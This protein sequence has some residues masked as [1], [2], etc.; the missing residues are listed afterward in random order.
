MD[1][2]CTQVCLRVCDCICV[3]DCVCV[4]VCCFRGGKT[5]GRAVVTITEKPSTKTH[6]CAPGSSLINCLEESRFLKLVSLGSL[7]R[8]D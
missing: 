6:L 8:F 5:T 4:C 2:S 3:C 7:W 1:L